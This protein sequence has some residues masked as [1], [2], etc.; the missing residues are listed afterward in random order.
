MSVLAW[1]EKDKEG[2]DTKAKVMGCEEHLARVARWEAY[3]LD[4][5]IGLK[6]TTAQDTLKLY[7]ARTGM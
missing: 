4:S 3:I 1:A 2:M 7:K 6:I 5:R